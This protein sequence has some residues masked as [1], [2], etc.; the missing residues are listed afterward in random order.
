MKTGELTTSLAVR[1]IQPPAAALLKRALLT[2]K[3]GSYAARI[4]A[5]WMSVIWQDGQA[6]GAVRRYHADFMHMDPNEDG[7]DSTFWWPAHKVHTIGLEGSKPSDPEPWQWLVQADQA[8]LSAVG[9]LEVHLR[10]EGTLYQAGQPVWAVVKEPGVGFVVVSTRVIAWNLAVTENDGSIVG[11]FDGYCC[12]SGSADAR[13]FALSDVFATEEEATH[14]VEFLRVEATGEQWLAAIGNGGDLDSEN[15]QVREDALSSLERSELGKARSR[16]YDIRNSLIA[17]RDQ[18]GL[19]RRDAITLAELLNKY[20]PPAKTDVLS[21]ILE[22]LE[23]T[24]EA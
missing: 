6:R 14:N 9:P 24:W 16:L 15:A 22:Q 23:L 2:G 1:F 3:D 5:Y 11:L 21:M 13:D 18:G 19:R 10:H 20:L 12:R 4:N 7:A 17:C 8:E